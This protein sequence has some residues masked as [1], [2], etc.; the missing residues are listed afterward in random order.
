MEIPLIEKGK[1]YIK[2]L[3]KRLESPKS[4]GDRD[5]LDFIK[6]LPLPFCLALIWFLFEN[7]FIRLINKHILPLSLKMNFSFI[8]HFLFGIIAILIIWCIRKCYKKTYFVPWNIILP[9]SLGIGIYI[10]CRIKYY[11]SSPWG[12]VGY[13]D[14]I[15]L[16]F[17][18][19]LINSIKVRY[20]KEEKKKEESNQTE[21]ESE[22]IFIPD[23]AL[24]NLEG[25]ELDYS[26][27]AE[28]LAKKIVA[29]KKENSFSIGLVAPWG[30]GKTTFLNFIQIELKKNEDIIIINFNPRHSYNV[31]NIQED[32]FNTLFSE[33]KKFD[34][35]FSSS[36][37]NYLK[38]IDVINENKL[39][40]FLFNTHKIWDRKI[41]KEKINTAISRISK[42]III[43]IEDFDRL[44]HEEIIEVLKLID[45]NASFTNLIFLTAYDR[46]YINNILNEK[47]SSNTPYFIDKFFDL[48]LPLPLRPYE[49]IFNY[50]INELAKKLHANPEEKEKYKSTLI[51]HME[52]LQP[53][54]STIRDV[55][56][57]LNLL[58][59][60]YNH[61]KESVEFKDYFFLYLIKYKYPEE[62]LNLFNK[63]YLSQSRIRCTLENAE[64][65]ASKE[66]LELL[67]PSQIEYSSKS[68]N[69]V[70]AFKTY[71]YETIYASSSIQEMEEIF[72]FEFDKVREYIDKAIS[73]KHIQEI[74]DF[75][76]AYNVLLFLTKEQFKRYLDVLL[77]INRKQEINSNIVFEKISSFITI[78]ISKQIKN[79]LH[80]SDEEYKSIMFDIIQGEYPYF[81]YNLTL[82]IILGLIEG[83]FEDIIFTQNDVLNIACKALYILISKDDK[84][85]QEHLTLLNSC[86]ERK[87]P[88]TEQF[89]FNEEACEAVRN[90][91]EKNPYSYFD[92][93]VRPEMQST[94]ANRNSIGCER[95][96]KHIFR[97]ADYFQRFIMAQSKESIPNIELIKNFWELYKNNNFNPIE[98]NNQINVQKK[99][100]NNLI[101]EIKE[102][103]KLLKIEKEYNFLYS[104]Q[105]KIPINSLHT[106]LPK[107]ILLL[108][109]INKN[110]LDIIK[111]QEIRNK[112][113]GTIHN[114]ENAVL[115][116]ENY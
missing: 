66:I 92:N 85:K 89:I 29:I 87:D 41:E 36:F 23:M 72:L 78:E 38:A 81:P 97:N 95:L 54:L 24:E 10:E 103:N 39:I 94:N 98:F 50:L 104:Q 11:G 5:L 100:N 49:N 19:F 82:E 1:Q 108:D 102:L 112:I 60:Q 57:F 3:T 17:G 91:I 56:R 44:L 37:K 31:S 40:K 106:L 110:D 45:G 65:A 2:A 22:P 115:F 21:N 73:D 114:I 52:S 47:C 109:R 111:K 43:I 20:T 88:N 42:R 12:I 58:L 48:E 68:I 64:K 116:H 99:I 32:F 34:F 16:L 101:E 62:Y 96:W 75:L 86:I 63:K 18:I 79:N 53:Y 35:R 90:A 77:Y 76:D 7:E 83:E 84:I 15:I 30:Y 28:K 51:Y 105:E 27:I 25:D 33:L 61:I 55:K 26:R 69:N 9:S 93:F 80:Y 6:A 14:I 13:S 59:C 4:I 67:F 70:L 107:Y 71:F 46:S 74:I 8:T 113:E